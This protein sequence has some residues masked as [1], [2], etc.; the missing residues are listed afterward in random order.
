MNLDVL[1]WRNDFENVWS[2]LEKNYPNN[3]KELFLKVWKKL[4]EIKPEKCYYAIEVSF[5][6]DGD[7][8]ILHV[9][10]KSKINDE[11]YQLDYIPWKY[12]FGMNVN[13]NEIK[14]IGEIEWLSHILFKITFLGF[15]DGL[16]A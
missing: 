1:I 14:E 9:C 6:S 15:L 12:W 11:H 8:K 3:D 7:E 2:K 4:R 16:N 10:G 5:I 13:E